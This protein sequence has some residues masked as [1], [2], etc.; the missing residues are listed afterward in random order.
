VSPHNGAGPPFI[1]VCDFDGT[2]T[3]EDVTNLIWDAHLPYDWRTALLPPSRDGRLSPLAMIA[4]GYGDVAVPADALL[5][6]VRPRAR[7]RDGWAELGALCERRGWPL[8][9][10]SHGLG[11]YI[12]CLLPPGVRVTSFEG[13]FEGGRWEVTLPE[14]VILDDGEDFKTHVVAALRARHPGHAAVYVGDGRLD[15][16]AARTC[17]RVFAVRGSPLVTHCRDA[18]VPCT[19]FDTFDEVAAALLS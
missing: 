10:V 6:Q 4:R 14:G 12:R 8:E 1:V 11:F 15:F 13:A 2:I 5:A 16:P 17:D 7:L 9:V 18:G 19:E 3:V